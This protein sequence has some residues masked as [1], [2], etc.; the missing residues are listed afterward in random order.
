MLRIFTI[1]SCLSLL[2]FLPFLNPVAAKTGDSPAGQPVANP[3]L[4]CMGAC[5]TVANPSS[6]LSGSPRTSG[7]PCRT[8]NS[9]SESPVR[10]DNAKSKKKSKHK[11]KENGGGGVSNST[12][13]L[14]KQLIQLLT[15]LLGGESNLAG[16]QSGSG[17]GSES[18][19]K[20]GKESEKKSGSESK[21]KSG[22]ESGSSAQPCPPSPAAS[23]GGG[24]SGYSGG[25][26]N[27][28]PSKAASPS[29][30]APSSAATQRAAAP[31]SGQPASAGGA[32]GTGNAA[33]AASGAPAAPAAPGAAAGGAKVPVGTKEVFKADFETGDTS[34][35]GKCQTKSTNGNCGKGSG[36][37]IQIVQDAPK[38]G[39]YAARFELRP[40]D[41]V[42]SGE[43]TEF[44]SSAPGPGSKEGDEYWFSWSQ[45]FDN[46][47]TPPT[48]NWYIILQW[49]D[50]SNSSPPIAVEV[51]KNG[52]IIVS[53]SGA[54]KNA[55]KLG[56]V[57]KG[58]WTD[59]VLHIKFSK[60]AG[61]GFIEGWE[62][63]VQTL[64]KYN[65]ATMGVGDNYLK[66]G[67][68]RGKGETSNSVVFVDEMRITAP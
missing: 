7:A 29:K 39:K 23:S 3:T 2:L 49:H 38:A 11:K 21:K 14:L 50:Q 15:S 43:R 16:I 33:P 40:G 52:D 51:Q 13:K 1:L 10:E 34:Q 65:R 30:A 19:K 67:I 36:Y 54:G 32:G 31:S 53:Q 56:T 44:H 46:S 28:T 58:V 20:S 42:A 18:K 57:K 25:T 17:S 24:T 9:V 45:K 41:T 64:P 6:A 60:N 4:F 62:N 35:W 27:T 68:Y 26:G 61:T 66:Q 48:S 8:N 63:G 5:P 59:Y 22:N 37:S 12:E 47:W 55:K